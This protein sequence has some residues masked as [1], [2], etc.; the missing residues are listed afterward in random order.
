VLLGISHL[1]AATAKNTL[2]VLL[3]H[4]ADIDRAAKELVTAEE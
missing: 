3:K 4:R 1:D 2:N